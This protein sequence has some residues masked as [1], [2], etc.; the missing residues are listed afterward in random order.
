MASLDLSFNQL[1]SVAVHVLA[2]LLRRPCH[3]LKR[4]DLGYNHIGLQGHDGPS[5]NR[6]AAKLRTQVA[7]DS[8]GQH[9]G[10]GDDES[11]PGGGSAAKS[12]VLESLSLAGNEL[13]AVSLGACL[14]TLCPSAG[15]LELDCSNCGLCADDLPLLVTLELGA[16]R[17]DDNVLADAG[18][19][20]IAR[21]LASGGSGAWG[22]LRLL[23]L[24]NVSAGD[25]GVQ[26]LAGALEHCG[27]ASSAAAT[28]GARRLLLRTLDLRDNRK[29]SSAAQSAVQ[30]AAATL[31]L[32][33]TRM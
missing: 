4:L 19:A 29:L 10:A 20:Q 28:R 24:R 31:T 30:R 17:L 13:C 6:R 12:A 23:S 14:S 2:D 8:A 7:H 16:L 33:E 22:A 15:G 11:H 1:S 27:R 9:A 18:L 32:L 5:S 25:K 26:Q 3:N 21:P